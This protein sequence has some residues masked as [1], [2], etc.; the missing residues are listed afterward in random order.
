MPIKKTNKVWVEVVANDIHLPKQNIKALSCLFKSIK[1]LKPS[2]ITLN[3]D[4]G[5][6]GTFSRHTRFSAPKCH[7]NDSQYYQ[8]SLKDYSA[9]NIFLDTIQKIAPGA[10]KRYNF[11]NHEIWVD[12]FIDESPRIRYE[13]FSLQERL[14]LHKRGY[15]VQ[16]YG[17]FTNLG[18]LRVTHG[19]Y[20]G[21][22]HAKKHV[23]MM[24][25]SILYGHLHDIQVYSKVTPEDVSH[26]AWC[27]G[28]LCNLNPE[29]L[30]SK[31][32]NWNHGFAVV[33]VW[34]DGNFQVDII[35]INKGRCIVNGIEIIG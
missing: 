28:C 3:G 7:W 19:L 11:G 24:G 12:D 6:W 16:Q 33:Y 27:N 34:P 8:E 4:I 22:H 13:K 14:S 20:T 10:R 35:R 26:M 30:R 18:K 25:A 23:D 29:Y 17:K 1:L 5:D 21:Q 2:G 15:E 9:V 32:Q 31:P